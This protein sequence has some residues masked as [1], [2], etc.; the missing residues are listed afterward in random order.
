MQNAAPPDRIGV[1]TS[2][3]T[4]FRS[5][6]GMVGMALAGAVF[7]GT[8]AAG[9]HGAPQVGEHTEA[10][11]VALDAAGREVWTQAIRRVYQ[12]CAVIAIVGLGLTSLLPDRALRRTQGAGPAA[13]E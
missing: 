2:A 9:D 5:M 11:A 10:V 7:A 6:G 1:A 13:A 8:L 3:A 12:V 4:F